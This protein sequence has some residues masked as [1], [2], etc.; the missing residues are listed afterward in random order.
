MARRYA[1]ALFDVARQNKTE[2]T[3]GRDVS[4]LA[5]LIDGHEQLRQVLSMPTVPA[6]RK[7]A[8]MDAVIA[9]SGPVV[10]EVQRLTTMLGDRDLLTILPDV[11]TAFAAL[12]NAANRTMPAE[13][14][15]A[16]PISDAARQALAVALG[17]ALDA[18]VTVTTR[19]DPAI[20]G[21]VVA[22]VGSVVYD[23]SVAGQLGRLRQRLTSHE[24]T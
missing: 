19:E 13:V 14:V 15:T 7:R 17:R 4:A 10:D 18:T 8:L 22:T 24:S 5:G 9:A 2:E 16:V 21:G 3:V 23:G 1:N 11:A 20:L 12:L 6:A